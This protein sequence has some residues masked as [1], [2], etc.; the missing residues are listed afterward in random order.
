MN[1][2][3]IKEADYLP[4]LEWLK[5]SIAVHNGEGSAAFFTRS[6]RWGWGWA[7]AYPETT[8]YLIPTL[9]D[10]YELT[11]DPILKEYAESCADWLCKIQMPSG[12]Y[13]SAYV[14]TNKP[15]IF[16]TGQILIGL[17][18]AYRFFEKKEYFS[19]LEKAVNWLHSGI[20]GGKIWEDHHYIKGY[21]PTYYT[22]VLFPMLRCNQLLKN[23]DL[24]QN[25][26]LV[27]NLFEKKILPNFAIEDWGF[28][29]DQPAPT[30]T[31]AYTI[32]GF[33][34]CALLLQDD[35]LFAKAEQSYLKL[36]E[37]AESKDRTAGE[38]S[39]D[40]SGNYSYRCVTGNAQLSII[41]SLFYKKTGKEIFS[42]ATVFFLSEIMKDPIQ[43][44]FPNW[45]GAVP[46]S[47]P[48]YGNYMKLRMPNWAAKFYL[49]AIF[50]QL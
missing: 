41:G 42:R 24:E 11:G 37:I 29:K 26:R 7:P 14:K 48:W 15:S 33:M 47:R 3:I 18:S 9:L 13:T 44:P 39:T 22:R 35:S 25:I 23:P 36:F 16:N 28:F 19:A 50:Q 1:P 8:G 38:Y 20:K 32:R 12:A 6:I 31:I 30:H 21:V 34:E 46:G 27:L 43:S 10:Y 45:N 5:R 49:D 17:E 2:L 4:T 40:W